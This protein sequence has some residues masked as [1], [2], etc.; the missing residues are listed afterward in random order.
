MVVQGSASEQPK[1]S[2]LSKETFISNQVEMGSCCG[3]VGVASEE[4]QPWE[5]YWEQTSQ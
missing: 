1:P 2:S 3:V 5:I 4:L